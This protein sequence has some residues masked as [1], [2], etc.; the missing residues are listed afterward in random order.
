M[1]ESEPD[2]C[3]FAIGDFGH[4]CPATKALA[5]AMNKYAED[6]NRTPDFILGLG[7]NFYPEGVSSVDD[8]LFQEAWQDV[9]LPH[10][11]LRVPWK[12]VLG[13]HD[14]MGNPQAQ[15]DFTAH[16]KNPSGLWQLPAQNYAFTHEVPAAPAPFSVDFFALDTNGCQGHVRRSHPESEQALSGHIARLQDALAASTADWKIVFAHHPLYTVGVNHGVLGRCLRDETYT[17]EGR[18]G[19]GAPPPLR[20]ARPLRRAR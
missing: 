12:L 11:R 20:P 2:L 8:P 16:D 18:S 7:D 9:F 5:E 6:T 19:V 15:I 17:F 1:V 3:F 13:N 10:Q 4:S 14:Y